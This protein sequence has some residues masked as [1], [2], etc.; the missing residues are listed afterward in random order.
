MREDKREDRGGREAAGGEPGTLYLTAT[1]IGN[2]DDMTPRALQVLGSADLIAA[3]DTRR[4]LQLLNHFGLKGTL[5]RYDENNKEKEGPVLLEK[6]QAGQTIALVTDAGFPGISDPGEAMAKLA[7][8]AGV[9]VVPV[10]GANACLTAL[11][12][13]GLPSTPFFFGGFLPKTKKNRAAQ[14]EAWKYLP[15][16]V[17]LYEAPHRITQVLEEILDAWGDRPLALGRELTKVHEEF[18]RGTVSGALTHLAEHPPRGEFVLV[19]GQ[20]TEA[21]PAADGPAEDPLE[22]VRRLIEQGVPKKDALRQVAKERKVS[23]RDLYNRLL[24]D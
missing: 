21:P 11:V 7:I 24:K 13:S 16:T 9:P 19:I 14:L 3:E 2:L 20:G 1:P 10:P 23:K 18:W 22:T 12:A 17:V 8:D 15:A 5:V 6:L 4:T